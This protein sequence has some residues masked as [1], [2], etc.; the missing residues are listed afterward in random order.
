MGIRTA[1]VLS[2]NLKNRLE[3]VSEECGLSQ[4]EI[5]RAGTLKELRRIEGE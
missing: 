3:N 1:L 5:I 2:E 4:S